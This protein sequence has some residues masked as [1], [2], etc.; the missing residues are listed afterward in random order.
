M[1]GNLLLAFDNPD[2]LYLIR[3]YADECG[4]QTQAVKASQDICIVAQEKNPQAI[5]LEAQGGPTGLTA[6]RALKAKESTR[7]IPVIVCYDRDNDLM[8][9]SD[10]AASLC[11]PILYRDFTAALGQAGILPGVIDAPN[12]HT[13]SK[14]HK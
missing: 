4:F 2:A 5:I 6:L 9:C 3:R 14:E 11:Q 10:I 1:A 12:Q 8:G 7:H 13:D